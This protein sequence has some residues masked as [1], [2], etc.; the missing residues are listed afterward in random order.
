MQAA[1][2]LPI[3]SGGRATAGSTIWAFCLSLTAY[4]CGAKRRYRFT[5][6]ITQLAAIVHSTNR[7][8]QYAP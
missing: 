3:A 5:T 8:K 7:L 1:P 6:H 4:C 2:D